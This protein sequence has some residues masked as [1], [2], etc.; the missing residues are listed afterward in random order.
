MNRKLLIRQWISVA[1][2]ALAAILYVISLVVGTGRSDV[3]SAAREM[4]RKVEARMLLLDH[5][6]E[7]ALQSEAGTWLA[8]ED[9]PGDM[10]IYRYQED[11][12]QSWVN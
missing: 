10:V 7:Q 4:S 6:I 5:Y 12:L 3:N 9:V 11:S 8:L 2:L 1:L